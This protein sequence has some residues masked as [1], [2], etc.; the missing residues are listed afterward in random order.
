MPLE[1]LDNRDSQ[2]LAKMLA[3]Y[4]NGRLFAVERPALDPVG[5]AVDFYVGCVATPFDAS[6][7]E[8][9]SGVVSIYGYTDAGFMDTI[10]DYTLTC[11][12][13]WNVPIDVCSWVNIARDPY[14]GSYFVVSIPGASCCIPSGSGSGS[15]LYY[16]L[17]NS[18]MS[19]ACTGCYFYNPAWLGDDNEVINSNMV[20]GGDSSATAFNPGRSLPQTITIGFVVTPAYAGSAF[21]VGISL[22][23]SCDLAQSCFV[24]AFGQDGYDTV[25]AI[26]DDTGYTTGTIPGSLFVIGQEYSLVITDDGT[27]ITAS[28]YQGMTLAVT[29]SN[30]SSVYGGN[31]IVLYPGPTGEALTSLS[32]V[33]ASGT[34]WEDN[35]N[36]VDGTLLVNHLP[37]IGCGSGASGPQY[38]CLGVPYYYCLVNSGSGS[39]S[40]GSGGSVEGC[41]QCGCVPLY[42]EVSWTGSGYTYPFDS[43]SFLIEN[44]LSISEECY[45]QLFGGDDAFIAFQLTFTPGSAQISVSCSDNMGNNGQ[46]IEGGLPDSWDCGND[47]TNTMGPITILDGTPVYPSSI[48]FTPFN[49][50]C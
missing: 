33:D 38:Y 18:G 31:V 28:I 7:G 42:Y 35:F 6:T 43:G 34:T 25:L 40:G 48:T 5:I 50:D 49:S 36:D 29:W 44:G 22:R 19:G 45:W 12:S 10:P 20:T 41:G 21:Y 2:R 11:L 17:T 1:L 4:E 15:G 23:A 8:P 46:I 27:T 32:V 39:G 3:D 16:C 47:A 13:L 9:T 24:T 37:Q 30:A 14:S 26:G